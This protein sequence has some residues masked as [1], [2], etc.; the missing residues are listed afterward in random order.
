ME[1]MELIFLWSQKVKSDSFIWTENEV[2]L[3]QIEPSKRKT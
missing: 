2:A 3:D 1:I